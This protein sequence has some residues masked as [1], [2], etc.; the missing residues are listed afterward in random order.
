MRIPPITHEVGHGRWCPDVESMV[1]VRDFGGTG[2]ETRV[3]GYQDLHPVLLAEAHTSTSA[4]EPEASL[5]LA[6]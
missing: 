6:T 5:L 3:N 2:W 1:E 4:P